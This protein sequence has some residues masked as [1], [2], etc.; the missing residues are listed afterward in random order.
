MAIK[1]G[2][3]RSMVRVTIS[4][5]LPEAF[6]MS[7]GTWRNCMSSNCVLLNRAT[8]A[9]RFS[10]LNA[11]RVKSFIILVALDISETIVLDWPLALRDGIVAADVERDDAQH[12]VDTAQSLLRHQDVSPTGEPEIHL[13]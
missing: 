5:T 2:V 9:T 8:A 11:A 13:L 6:D 3:A 4:L 12:N 10:A 7:W 1:L